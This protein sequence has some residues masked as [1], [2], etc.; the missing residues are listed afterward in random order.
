MFSG[1]DGSLPSTERSISSSKPT[2][3]RPS[4]LQLPQL[5]S[6]S[7]SSS[8]PRQRSAFSCR[9]V[10]N[11]GSSSFRWKR[12]AI[13]VG[14][15]VDRICSW[16]IQRDEG[17]REGRSTLEI[18]FYERTSELL[19]TS[20]TLSKTLPLLL[21][22]TETL[23]VFLL[24]QEPTSSIDDE[25][26]GGWGGGPIEPK[27][28]GSRM[29]VTSRNS[30]KSEERGR[31]RGSTRMS[32]SRS[33]RRRVSRFSVF[34]FPS[35]VMLFAHLLVSLSLQISPNQPVLRMDSTHH[36]NQ[37]DNPPPSAL[38]LFPRPR[39][40]PRQLVASSASRTDQSTSVQS[41]Y[42]GR[43][44]RSVW[45]DEGDGRSRT[46]DDATTS[47]DSRRESRS[48]RS[49]LRRPVSFI[50]PPHFP[51]VSMSLFSVLTIP[52]FLDLFLCLSSRSRSRISTRT[53]EDGEEVLLSRTR[54][55]RGGMCFLELLQR[56]RREGG[57]ARGEVDSG[58][59]R[60]EDG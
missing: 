16:R 21:T 36:Q 44:M 38:A 42:G 34:V 8:F 25:D 27:K 47:S 59:G 51:T 30:W 26:D 20:S 2:R 13:S 50:Q 24:Q 5:S 23:S 9:R 57:V 55:S 43:G 60:L 1:I 58:R 40:P 52:F 45:D 19:H 3:R 14:R 32:G 12:N 18:A 35:R 54:S 53:T 31:S 22:I 11:F 28:V 6:T 10:F 15:R 48:S 33:P 17:E 39:S 41:A 7:F 46:Q 29:E 4:I 56:V 37:P 49:P